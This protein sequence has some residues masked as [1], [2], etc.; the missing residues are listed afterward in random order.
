MITRNAAHFLPGCLDALRRQSIADV[1]IVVVDDHSDDDTPAV[2][3]SAGDARIVYVRNERHAG[4]AASRNRGV[5]LARSPSVFFTDADCRPLRSW[6]E[7]G[8]RTFAERDCAGVEGRTLPPR[9][10]LSLAHRSV[11]NEEGGQWQTC[12]IAYRRDAILGAGGF[13]ARYVNAYEDRDLALRVQRRGAIVFCPDMV[14]FHELIRWTWK[15]V[16]SDGMRARDRVRL[17]VEHGD[18]SALWGRVVEPRGLAIVLCPLILLLYFPVRSARD[19][20]AIPMLW[21]RSVVQR[22]AIWRA[23]WRARRFLV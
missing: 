3:G 10:V 15:R 20:A 13:D 5:A 4:V 6:V 23:A 17:I 16:V 22:A 2:V 8:L 21:V 1:E 12:N 14:V 11:I 7:E 19:L 18:R 9:H